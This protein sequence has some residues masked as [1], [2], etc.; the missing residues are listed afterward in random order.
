MSTGVTVDNDTRWNARI[1]LGTTLAYLIMQ[2]YSFFYVSDPTNPSAVNV[3]QV[4]KRSHRYT[5][6]FFWRL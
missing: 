5:L 2:S 6:L 1:A 4:R 3:E